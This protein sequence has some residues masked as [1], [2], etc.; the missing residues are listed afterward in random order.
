M[1]F[2]IKQ[3]VQLAVRRAAVVQLVYATSQRKIEVI[4]FWLNSIVFTSSV[5]LLVSQHIVQQI[6]NPSQKVEFGY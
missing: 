2:C 6:R 1:D 4:P 5:I 3:N